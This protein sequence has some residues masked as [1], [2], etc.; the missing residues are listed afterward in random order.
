[1]KTLAPI[2]SLLVGVA[3]LITGHGLQVT[4]VPLRAAAE[5]W[6]EFQI[7]AVG[8]AYYVGFVAGCLGA[9]FLI[10]RSGHIRAFAALASLTTAVTVAQAV[11]VDF[12]PWVAFRF[13]VG[14]ALA[15]LYM[16]IESWLN[17]QA[18]N[19]TRGLVMSLYI[20]VN[21][22]AITVGQ[23]AVTLYPPTSFALFSLA[24]ISTT[25]AVVPVVLTRSAQPAP[26]TLVRFRP[27]ALYRASPA[28]IVG[29]T[30]IGV[31]NGAFW[32]LGTV[33][34]VGAG[35]SASMAAVFMSAAVV[36]GAL[37][38]W[39]AG[40]LS[41]SIDRRFVLIGLLA[42][43]AVFG[44][45][46]AFLPLAGT[47]VLVVA[48]LFGVA[49]LPTYSI[50]AA[51]SYDHAAPGTHVE[52]AAG[53]L[54]ANGAGAI[55]GPLAASLMME[56]LGSARLFLF[57]ALVQLALAAFIVT[58]LRLRAAPAPAEKTDFDL[59]ATAPVGAVIPPEALNPED[60]NVARP[61]A[62]G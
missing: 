62:T 57:T 14:A 26:I 6:S 30:L 7:G 15:G 8:S 55:A 54:L 40:R 42:A 13:A 58:R 47:A 18:T 11:F 53:I 33:F 43:G 1:M 52:T 56:H 5:S 2:A 16:I 48:F 31:A 37:S 46:L 32:S 4:L 25:L 27:L 9:P 17:D 39:P 36:G 49:T 3:F 23:L 41:D 45:A 61:D 51:H 35:L 10:L 12:W 21:F 22:A 38:Q 24:G 29:V 50:A 59:A 28:G 34:A 20:V 44:L 19:E 60:P